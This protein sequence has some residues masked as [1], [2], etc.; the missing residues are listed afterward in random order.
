[1]LECL[2]RMWVDGPHR[3]PAD[4]A[5]SVR[6][7][8]ADMAAHNVAEHALAQ[9]RMLERGALHRLG[10]VTAPVLLLIG[11]ADSTDI[12]AVTERAL[13]EVPGARRTGIPG[14]GHMLNLEQP[15]ACHSA[16]RMETTAG[17]TGSAQIGDNA[18]LQI[19]T[20]FGLGVD[21]VLRDVRQLAT[22]TE[23]LDDLYVA[24]HQRP[25]WGLRAALAYLLSLRFA[26]HHQLSQS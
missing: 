13:R 11:D 5:A 14:A 4:V 24:F 17:R 25:G 22:W 12:F 9:G 3:Q 6:V 21:D 2:L 19:A 18:A 8:C 16:A 15:D 23:P 10:D 20:L 1:V 26:M 7:R